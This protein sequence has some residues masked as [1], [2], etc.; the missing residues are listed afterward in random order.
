M[1]IEF[2]KLNVLDGM[3]LIE[4]LHLKEAKYHHTCHSKYNKRM[5]DRQKSAANLVGS[6]DDTFDISQE[7]SS[8]LCKRRSGVQTSK[9]NLMCCFCR[10]NDI[11]KNLSNA[12]TFHAKT[13]KA[14]SNHVKKL[15]DTWIE[16]AKVLEDEDLLRILSSGDVAS[17]E[18]F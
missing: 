6:A 9:E 16:M 11:E 17:N 18:L 4:H 12:G 8:P 5:L 15:T 14:D 1:L 2:S 13:N 3:D 7:I 10:E